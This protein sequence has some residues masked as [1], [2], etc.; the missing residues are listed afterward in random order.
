MICF[1]WVQKNLV[2]EGK[3]RIINFLLSRFRGIFFYVRIDDGGGSEQGRQS[4]RDLNRQSEDPFNLIWPT[5]LTQ[6]PIGKPAL[7]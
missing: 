7:M 4:S 1:R 2:K 5:G 3:C 6:S